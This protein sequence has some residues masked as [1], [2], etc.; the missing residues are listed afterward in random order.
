MTEEVQAEVRLLGTLKGGNGETTGYYKTWSLSLDS[1]VNLE[2]I[3]SNLQVEID[4]NGA[5]QA[6][7]FQNDDHNSE[8]LAFLRNWLF[9]AEPA[10]NEY[11]VSAQVTVEAIS[12]A[13][14]ERKVSQALEDADI[15]IDN[16]EVS[17]Y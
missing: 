4:E 13:E 12:Q 14:A 8:L 9:V 17:K 2:E 10:V 7:F 6:V 5:V 15:S 3:L 16:I 1:A 11:T